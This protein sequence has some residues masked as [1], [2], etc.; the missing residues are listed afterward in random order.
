MNSLFKQCAAV[1]LNLA[2]LTSQMSAELQQITFDSAEWIPYQSVGQTA[3]TG[4]NLV[5][6]SASVSAQGAGYGGGNALNIPAN[7]LEE[8]RLTR[9]ITWN[10]AETTAFID[11]RIKP[12]ANPENS[13]SN[14]V[15][16][17]TQLAFQ[18]PQGSNVGE[19]WVYQGSDGT[20]PAEWIRT[21]GT[22]NVPA[23]ATNADGYVRLTLRHDYYH[24]LWDLF[25]DDKLAAANLSFET[26]I[27]GNLQSIDFFGSE[28]GD[29]GDWLVMSCRAWFV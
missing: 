6:G 2:L 4:W 23:G 1:A 20:R 26:N 18:V 5:T 27:I 16:N 21:A 22:F 13:L 11:L 12:A 29:Q 28:A 19:I 25:I 17:G 10:A 24:K 9:E 8:T 3:G 15:T 7:A 14:I